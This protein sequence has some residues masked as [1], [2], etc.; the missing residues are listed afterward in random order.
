MLNSAAGVP[1]VYVIR[2]HSTGYKIIT[3]QCATITPPF[4]SLEYPSGLISAGSM[5][6]HERTIEVLSRAQP[7]Q[8][9]TTWPPLGFRSVFAFASINQLKKHS[10]KIDSSSKKARLRHPW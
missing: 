1:R 7:L 2:N 4:R 6:E 9:N 5:K 10:D 3:H 8:G